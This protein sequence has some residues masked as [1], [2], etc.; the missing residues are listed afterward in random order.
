MT[1]TVL[2]MLEEFSISSYSLFK[3]DIGWEFHPD[4]NLFL[5]INGVGKTTTIRAVAFA[6]VGREAV[7]KSNYFASRMSGLG[8][9]KPLV[10]ISFRLGEIRFKVTRRLD[11]LE[12]VQFEYEDGQARKQ[13]EKESAYVAELLR[14]AGIPTIEDF[15]FLLQHLLIREEEAENTLWNAEDHS[16]VLRLIFTDGEFEREY[17]ALQQLLKDA[18]IRFS[19]HS[20]LLTRSR[21]ELD[22]LRERVPVSDRDSKAQERE[23]LANYLIQINGDFEV[24]R[25]QIQQILSPIDSLRGTLSVLED[26][27]VVIE[28][29]IDSIEEHLYAAEAH[30]HGGLYDQHTPLRM[31]ARKL[32][33]YGVCMFCDREVSGS[34]RSELEQTIKKEENC[35]FCG[36]KWENHSDIPEVHVDSFYLERKEMRLALSALEQEIRSHT[37]ELDALVREETERRTS[38]MSLERQKADWEREFIQ[39]TEVS[40]GSA[41]SDIDRLAAH[42][43]V[44]ERQTAEARATRDQALVQIAPLRT[45]AEMTLSQLES[46]FGDIFSSMV[47][48]CLGEDGSVEVQLKQK[49]GDQAEY[50]VFRPIMGGR[51]RK[52]SSEVSKS[53]AIL[54]DYAFRMTVLA[55]Y[56]ELTGWSSFFI[57]ETFEGVL[58]VAY[59]QRIGR[60]L[61]DFALDSGHLLVVVNNLSR[62]DFLNALF[63]RISP[64]SARLDRTLN[65]LLFGRL[66]GV[67]REGVPLYQR[68]GHEVFGEA[69][70]A[71]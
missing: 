54:L 33:A 59:V 24:A 1:Q 46:R 48:Q 43:Q 26:Q 66:L 25:A 7:P 23:Q 32:E 52:S 62:S 44:L 29:R 28:E 68:I 61:G 8:P 14:A 41:L 18:H 60:L 56:K 36:Q 45:R 19:Q 42:V 69:F 40:V 31:A 5:G 47:K 30:Y 38:L 13:S 51:V 22:Q 34:L 10:S 16:K 67:Q 53:Q 63:S 20:L 49:S 4:V 37:V 2:P 3:R 57:L 11:S 55:L 50:A 64:G 12:F 21:N 27:K 6:I 15:A 71:I 35:L 58:D 39:L 17:S 9:N 70:S 65:F